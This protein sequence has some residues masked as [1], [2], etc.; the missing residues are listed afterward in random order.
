M[1]AAFS[2]K[3]GVSQIND[4]K[5]RKVY[6][7]KIQKL[8]TKIDGLQTKTGYKKT[9]E[10]KN[11][12]LSAGQRKQIEKFAD[13]IS[14]FLEIMDGSKRKL[15]SIASGI[16]NLKT[17]LGN[18]ATNQSKFLEAYYMAMKERFQRL[19][20]EIANTQ[21]NTYVDSIK[22]ALKKNR[23]QNATRAGVVGYG[24]K[25]TNFG[26]GLKQTGYRP[27]NK[28]KVLPSKKKSKS[29]KKKK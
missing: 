2:G 11:T 27:A 29:T 17:Q 12:N 23:I 24:N 3:F 14:E 28:K 18:K 20:Q 16:G 10:I 6:I 19:E 22:N 15:V 7:E 1:G 25:P 13:E 5:A 4:D 9:Q 26:P 8:L 21:T